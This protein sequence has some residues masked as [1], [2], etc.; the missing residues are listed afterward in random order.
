MLTAVVVSIAVGEA[1]ADLPT[2]L[3]LTN[4]AIAQ[5]S[6]DMSLGSYDAGV[7]V[8]IV[9]GQVVVALGYIEALAGKR[10]AS[11]G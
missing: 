11:A 8:S 3:Y 5:E 9:E 6:Y 2:L 1:A 4:M 7:I 10:L